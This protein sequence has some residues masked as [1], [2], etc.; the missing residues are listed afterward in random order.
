[1]TEMD[2]I[3]QIAFICHQANKEWCAINGDPTQKDWSEAE[4]WQRISAIKG[5]E[6]ALENPNAPASA[7]HEAW[8]TDKL[9]DGW[10]YGKE[11][12][13]TAK[14]HPCLVPFDQ[15]PE[16]QQKKDKLFKAIV[17]ALS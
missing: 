3:T 2:K 8:S 15:L 11:K 14:T 5:V 4:N 6:F 13:A 9:A 16:F 1:M 10:I 7:Q 17:A 12:D